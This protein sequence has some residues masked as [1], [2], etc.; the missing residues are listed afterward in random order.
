MEKTIR[1]LLVIVIN[2]APVRRLSFVKVWLTLWLACTGLSAFADPTLTPATG[3]TSVSADTTI[4]AGGSGT[5]TMLTGPSLAEDNSGQIDTGTL[6]L[7]VPSGFQFNTN[8]SVTVKVTGS[9]AA[10]NNINGV[11]NNGTIP[12]T[13]TTNTISITISSKS[14]DFAGIHNS[15]TLTWQNVQVVPKTGT[16]IT[17][18]ITNSGSAHFPGSMNATN[19]G[20]LAEVGGATVKLTFGTQP[21]NT[22]HGLIIAPAVTVRV[23]DQFGNLTSSN[24][25]VTVA[26]GTNPGGGTLSGTTTLSATNGTA[27]FTNLSIDIA[28]R[29]YT[30]VGRSTGFAGITSSLFDITSI[31]LRGSATMANTNNG[32]TLTIAKPTGV[33]QGDVMIVNITQRHGGD[34]SSPPEPSLSG[35]TPIGSGDDFENGG[36]QHRFILL[37]RVAGGSEPTS[38]VFNLNETVDGA[39]GAIVAF[40]GVDTNTGPFDVT[41]GSYKTG[42]GTSISGVTAITNVSANVAVLM[43][44]AANENNTITLFSTTNPGALTTLYGG[45]ANNN[46]TVGAGWGTKATAGSTGTGSATSSGNSWGAILLAL[47]PLRSSSSTTLTSSLNP[48][49]PGANVIFTA[50]LAATPSP[51]GTVIF[52]DGTTPFYTNTLASGS[53]TATNSALSHGAHTINAIYS[54]DASYLTSTGSVSQVINTPP[55]GGSTVLGTTENTAVTLSSNKLARVATDADGDTLVITMLNSPTNTGATLAFNSGT[56]V[57]YTPKSNSTNAD[58][59]TYVVSDPF[60]ATATNTVYVTVNALNVSGALANITPL[61]GGSMQILA[62]GSPGTN[63]WIQASTNMTTDPWLSIGTNA[64]LANGLILFTDVNAS[65]FPARFYRLAVP[66]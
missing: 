12:A 22:A 57:L 38:Y 64:A 55:V 11:A 34:S 32:T 29:G 28:S 59:F 5:Y 7:N 58:S 1:K 30:L 33:V 31:G 48:A 47:K 61:P 6:V 23:Q 62:S 35:W 2:S 65:S 41:P 63:Y 24:A 51:T 56:T 37:Y 17:G 19:W 40:S 42:T 3:G 46:G 10:A 26:I 43:F 60:G 50:T 53:T 52:K 45:T 36:P 8:V 27:T 13:V 54:G 20:T 18:N 44:A 4:A 39:A 14:S 49:L 15:N 21:T 9:A 25:S 16:A 66:K